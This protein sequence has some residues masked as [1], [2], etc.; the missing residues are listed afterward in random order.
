MKYGSSEFYRTTFLSATIWNTAR[1]G[2]IL[3][4]AKLSWPQYCTDLTAVECYGNVLH[5]H[6][7]SRTW[8]FLSSKI[9]NLLIVVVLQTK[10]FCIRSVVIK[11]QWNAIFHQILSYYIHLYASENEGGFFYYIPSTRCPLIPSSTHTICVRYRIKVLL[12]C[13]YHKS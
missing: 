10:S 8:P 12:F 9:V 2:D 6:L 11:T 4:L 3:L 7:I 13:L 1:R 5:P